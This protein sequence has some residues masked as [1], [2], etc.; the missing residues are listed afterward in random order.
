[1]ID[2]FT[3]LAEAP[4][5]D[6]PPDVGDWMA[7]ASHR[8]VTEALRLVSPESFAAGTTTHLIVPFTHLIVPGYRG[9]DAVGVKRAVYRANGLQ[10]STGF[11]NVYGKIAVRQVEE[12]Q[13]RVGLKA[14]GQV[15]PETIRKLGPYFDQYAFYLYEGYRPGQNPTQAKRDR[16]LAYL[17]W[18]YNQRAL[19][20]YAQFRPM[21]LL[22]DLY[23]LPVSE[24]CSTF[25]TKGAKAAGWI[26]PN[27]FRFNGTGNTETL[28]VHGRRISVAEARVGDAV[29][30]SSPQHVGGY[31]GHE[32]IISLGSSAGPSLTSVYYRRDLWQVRTY[33]T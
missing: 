30:Y 27:G 10:V 14:D 28:V 17:L 21:E 32:R 24:D 15:G 6:P 2:V 20:Y 7:D 19:I 5:D 29:L 23:H 1:M 25:Y 8:P 16:M 11:T 31:V 26:D 4:L 22:N 12:F 18:G 33:L 9:R 3:D 13:D